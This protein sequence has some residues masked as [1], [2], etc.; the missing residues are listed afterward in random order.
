VV[1][2]ELPV[3]KK[4]EAP[5]AEPPIAVT[6][7]PEKKP[8]AKVE[9]EEPQSYDRAAA[10]AALEKLKVKVKIEKRKQEDDSEV[11]AIETINFYG[12]FLDLM[13]EKMAERVGRIL[14]PLTDTE[15]L[16]FQ[17][18][19]HP[20]CLR[21]LSGMTKLK[22][23]SASM[24]DEGFAAIAGLNSLEQL[25][26]AAGRHRCSDAAM[27]HVAKLT[28]LTELDLSGGKITDEGLALLKPLTQLKMLYVSETPITGKS[29]AHLDWPELMAITL[30]GS[31]FTDEG[32]EQLSR[33]PKLKFV[34]ASKTGIT[35]VGLA[36]LAKVKNLRSLYLRGTKVSGKGLAGVKLEMLEAKDS[37]FADAGLQAL[38]AEDNPDLYNLALEGTK[39]TDEG[40]T[41]LHKLPA[42]TTLWLDNTAIT[43]AGLEH[44][45]KV[46][47]LNSLYLDGTQ[48][49]E[50]GVAKL[51]AAI[52]KCQI[53]WKPKK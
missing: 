17:R 51:K 38:T 29:L 1:P 5:P 20:A 40:L 18:D 28:S 11:D 50:A 48:V 7:A 26:T 41:D 46:P 12:S 37:Q 9:L 39:V 47:K 21:H 42:L 52:P 31:G 15:K 22:Q 53:D 2:P 6:P 25:T 49:T 13:D 19:I 14:A 24:D 10:L 35:D 23:I 34:Q 36:H 32:L 43:D 45:A 44:L 30:E 27:P 8:E 33:Y 16:W 4:V 3:A